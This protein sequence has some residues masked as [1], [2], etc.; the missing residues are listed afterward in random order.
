MSNLKAKRK[1]SNHEELVKHITS[2][3]TEFDTFSLPIKLS[4]TK[5]VLTLGIF[6]RK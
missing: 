1:S 5:R 6:R 2:E 4:L 3:F